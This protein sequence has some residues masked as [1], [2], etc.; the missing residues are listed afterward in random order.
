MS[1]YSE[2]NSNSGKT[3]VPTS[4]ASLLVPT[5]RDGKQTASAARCFSMDPRFRMSTGGSKGPSRANVYIGVPGVSHNYLVKFL[6]Y[7]S[8]C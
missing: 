1:T 4:G 2:R 7:P 3:S 6:L 5:S 8:Q